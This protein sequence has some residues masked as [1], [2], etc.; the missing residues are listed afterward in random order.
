VSDR[1]K[2]V[3]VK[4]A[5]AAVLRAAGLTEADA[6]RVWVLIHEQVEGTW[7]AGGGVVRYA[8]LVAFAQQSREAAVD[9]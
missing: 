9:A 5:T 2:T 1:R 8:E 3:L 4:D 7:G 6:L